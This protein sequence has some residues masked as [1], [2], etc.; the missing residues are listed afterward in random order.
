[1]CG[2]TLAECAVVRSVGASVIEV[3]RRS[4]EPP[5]CARGPQAPRPRGRVFQF[6]EGSPF[7][8]ETFVLRA[9]DELRVRCTASQAAALRKVRGIRLLNESVCLLEQLWE[10]RC[11]VEVVVGWKCPLR[12]SPIPLNGHDWL[13]HYSAVPLAWLRPSQPIPTG[14]RAPA[15]RRRRSS[16]LLSTKPNSLGNQSVHQPRGRA[17]GAGTVVAVGDVVLLETHATFSTLHGGG[18]GDFVLVREV[19]TGLGSVR[20]CP[21]AL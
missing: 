18:S 8:P 9:G 17:K 14:G 19:D 7:A 10:R 4:E 20:S 16:V 12:N 1:M 3:C 11:V 21:C 5:A 2:N 15:T 13:E 6:D